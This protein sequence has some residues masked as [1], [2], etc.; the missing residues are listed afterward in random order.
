MVAG[1]AAAAVPN[2]LGLTAPAA[3]L[4]SEEAQRSLEAKRKRT[5]RQNNPERTAEENNRRRYRRYK[6]KLENGSGVL[7]YDAWLA[8]DPPKKPKS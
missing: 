6:G 4:A 3:P 2:P 1:V 7:A 8:E 5:M